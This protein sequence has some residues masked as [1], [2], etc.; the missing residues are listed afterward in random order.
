M[1]LIKVNFMK[2]FRFALVFFVL[3]LPVYLFPDDSGRIIEYQEDGGQTVVVVVMDGIGRAEARKLA[4]ARAAELVV[5][6]GGRYFTID[7][8]EETQVIK[9]EELPSN[10]RFYGNMYQE[11]IIEKDF[12]KSAIQRQETPMSNTYPAIRLVFTSYKEKPHSK[13]LDACKFTDCK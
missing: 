10:Q 12:G 13:A 2:L 9:S 1:W 4:R 8:E 5:E 11:L 6:G 7:S 3:F